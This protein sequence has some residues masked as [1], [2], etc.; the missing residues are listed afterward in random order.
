[1]H[2]SIGPSCA[3]A[4]RDGQMT[5]WTHTQGVYPD[6]EAHRAKC[7]VMPP[8]NVRCI[9]VEGS[10]CYGH[11][12]ADDAAADAALIARRVPG[13][14]VRVQWMRE[15]EHR[16]EPYGPGDGDQAEG[17]ARCRRQDRRLGLRRVEQHPFDAAGRRGRLLA[18]QH[19]AQPF[20]DAAAEPL[21]LPDGGGDRNAIPL[22]TFPNARVVIT[23]SRHAGA[24]LGAARRSAPMQTCSRSRASWTSWRALAP[25]RSSSG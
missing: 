22:Y 21:P 5:V 8:E 15:Q 23:S 25:I 10:G 7:C 1:M 18:A 9:H 4:H 2:G 6:R 24:R 3:V 19:M 12:G 16:W 14:P 13:V 11:N 20:A 17:A